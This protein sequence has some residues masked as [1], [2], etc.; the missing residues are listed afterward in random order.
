MKPIANEKIFVTRTWLPDKDEY[1][2]CLNRAWTK[3]WIT[4]HGELEI[5]LNE[6]L[7]SYFQV[8]YLTL[9]GNGT[10]ALQLALHACGVRGGEV[11]TTPF[12]YVATSTAIAWEGATAVY[13]DIEPQT[14]MPSAE[15]IRS[16]ITG[17]TRAILFVN[18]FGIPGQVEEL[19]SL[20][21]EYEIP[22]IFD[23]AHAFG[24]YYKNHPLISYGDLSACSFHAT[25]VFH[26]VEGGSLACKDPE[27]ANKIR[28]MSTF[29]HYYDDY[30][31]VGI[32]AKLSE[33]HAAMGLC[34]LDHV[35]NLCEKR[36]TISKTYDSLLDFSIISKPNMPRE[37]V[38]NYAY[39]PVIFETEKKLL[40]CLG[41]LE[42]E[43]IFPRRYFHPSL[44]TLDFIPHR[45]S[46]P[47]SRDISSRICCLPIYP[48]MPLNVVEKVAK[49]IAKS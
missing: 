22:L 2:A 19:E 14:L 9:C 32:N 25:K 1:F 29:G 41:R 3:R 7:R 30:Q 23:S 17:Q 49:E 27:L 4:N 10:L 48:D 40:N 44:D 28:L 39:Y 18:V 38:P 31:C 8:P 24:V 34:M 45:N 37:T 11:I 6:K 46:C 47:K 13:V 12:T 36:K 35:G 33:F 21:N 15:K 42:R 5:E 43:G 16:A 26:T 20:A